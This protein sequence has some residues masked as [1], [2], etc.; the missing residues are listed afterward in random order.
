MTFDVGLLLIAILTLC[1]ICAVEVG[2]LE[3]TEGAMT[4][5]LA[6]HPAQLCS[7]LHKLTLSPNFR[8]TNIAVVRKSSCC[9][10][11]DL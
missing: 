8:Q 11:L 1:D 4:S 5:N 6:C 3:V 9:V 10:L 2:D 7:V